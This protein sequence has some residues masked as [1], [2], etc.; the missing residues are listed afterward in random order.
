MIP[1]AIQRDTVLNEN[2]YKILFKIDENITGNY[3]FFEAKIRAE[4]KIDIKY[5]E[6]KSIYIENIKKNETKYNAFK[7]IMKDFNPNIFYSGNFVINRG[8]NNYTLS[9]IKSLSSGNDVYF[10]IMNIYI[11]RY[12]YIILGLYVQELLDPYC[13]SEKEL[14]FVSNDMLNLRFEKVDNV[15]LAAS[16]KTQR[17]DN[18]FSYSTMYEFNCGPTFWKFVYVIITPEDL[19]LKEPLFYDTFKAEYSQYNDRYIGYVSDLG[20]VYV[21]IRND[22]NKIVAL[23][24]PNKFIQKTNIVD[25]YY[26]FIEED[27]LI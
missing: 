11:P 7:E 22:N 15:R 24:V 8:N 9:G 18:L 1:L 23:K 27:R 19:T 4:E 25:P 12:I 5:I 10:E 20:Y 16:A 13:D 6:S 21:I 14:L 2:T 26:I 3:I 17:E